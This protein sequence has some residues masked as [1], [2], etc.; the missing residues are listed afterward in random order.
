MPKARNEELKLLLYKLFAPFSL[1]LEDAQKIQ[2][3]MGKPDREPDQKSQVSDESVAENRPVAQLMIV[4]RT[5]YTK[6]N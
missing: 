1:H 3:P 2:E 5:T 4:N 6:Q